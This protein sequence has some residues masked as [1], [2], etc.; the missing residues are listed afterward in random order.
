MSS[1]VVPE[2]VFGPLVNAPKAKPKAK[3][4]TKRGPNGYNLF[5]KNIMPEVK[6]GHPD[7]NHKERMAECGRRWKALHGKA[8]NKRRRI[9]DRWRVGV[10]STS[11]RNSRLPKRQKKPAF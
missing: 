8:E 1:F 11:T 10:G 9:T 3:P 2:G 4:K 7:L 6:A 5:V